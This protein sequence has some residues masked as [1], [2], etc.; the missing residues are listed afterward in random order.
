[1]RQQPRIRT[2]LNSFDLMDGPHTLTVAWTPARFRERN[3]VL[4]KELF[5]AFREATEI[6]NQ[7]RRAAAAL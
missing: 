3:P 5:A 1:V 6:V 4:Y 7:D 2:I